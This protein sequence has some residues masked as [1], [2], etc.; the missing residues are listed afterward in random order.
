M[1]VDTSIGQHVALRP[2]NR[3]KRRRRPRAMW[4]LGAACMAFLAYSH[5]SAWTVAEACHFA[6][7]RR[8]LDRPWDALFP[9]PVT[10]AIAANALSSQPEDLGYKLRWRAGRPVW[11]MRSAP[12]FAGAYH[13]VDLAG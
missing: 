4:W 8:S 6:N 7:G 1:T 13:F 9:F 3:S 11:I 2:A 10:I 12:H 5:S